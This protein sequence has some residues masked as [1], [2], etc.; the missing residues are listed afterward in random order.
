MCDDVTEVFQLLLTKLTLLQ[1]NIE[2]MLA[3]DTEDLANMLEMCRLCW[4]ID[5]YII[6]E[7][8]H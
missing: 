4:I 8:E 2:L 6:E 3:N 5:D 1:L 7:H